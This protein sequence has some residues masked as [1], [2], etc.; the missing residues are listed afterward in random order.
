[1]SYNYYNHSFDVSAELGYLLQSSEDFDVKITVGKDPDVKDFG[2][3]SI[4]LRARSVYFQK[5]LSRHWAREEHGT[6][7]LK[8]PNVSPDTFDTILKY[9]YTGTIAFDNVGDHALN[10]LL[11]SDEFE[12]HNLTECTQDHI[13][14][15]H[16]SWIAS[17]LLILIRV[18]SHND[19]F[20]KL[21]THVLRL[22]CRNPLILF[23][24][25]DFLTLD[26]D[27]L[28]LL[29]KSDDLELEEIEIWNYLVKWGI[30]HSEID[31]DPTN[32]TAQDFAAFRECVSRCIPSIRFCQM[33]S[34]EY[35]IKVRKVFKKV[36]PE[37]I[38]EQVLQYHLNPG[39]VDKSQIPPPRA[40]SVSLDSK[41]INPKDAAIISSWIDQKEDNFYSF[42]N[43]PYKF[44]LLL[45]GSRDGFDVKTFHNLCDFQGPTVIVLKMQKTGELIGGYNPLD[46]RGFHYEYINVDPL[47]NSNRRVRKA[48][49]EVPYNNESRNTLDSF[50]FSLTN[51]ANPVLSRIAKDQAIFWDGMKG[52]CFGETDLCMKASS[53]S[54]DAP[55][56]VSTTYS[57]M[58]SSASIRQQSQIN[59]FSRQ[60]NYQRKITDTEAFDVEEFEVF[61]VD[62]YYLQ[63]IRIVNSIIRKS[64]ELTRLGYERGYEIY[65]EIPNDKLKIIFDAC[66]VVGIFIFILSFFIYF[67]S[68]P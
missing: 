5:A 26:E 7:I 13:I 37:E 47:R 63:F 45:R 18:V 29:L 41:L 43:N 36:I 35:Y 58:S 51:R 17:N 14:K 66:V 62:N 42:A 19:R 65:S 6:Y 50:I 28:Y 16:S 39:T 30:A 68:Q 9:I 34:N 49:C 25:D 27:A 10:I 60:K 2:A 53:E 48:L 38:D 59:W 52:P 56:T 61:L 64:W 31:Q 8:K 54:A 46:W 40:L 15:Y 20:K 23:E 21:R 33:S 1:M 44:K 12:L 24:S 32:W 4:I 55:I 67:A 11:A 57:S 3:H 22:I